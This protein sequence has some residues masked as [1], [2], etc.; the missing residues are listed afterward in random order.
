MHFLICGIAY[1]LPTYAYHVHGTEKQLFHYTFPLHYEFFTLRVYLLQLSDQ[2]HH[3]H[4][5]HTRHVPII[6][7][8]INRDTQLHVLLPQL[9]KLYHL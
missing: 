5:H 1:Y 3:A 9:A 6:C 4:H 7:H 2:I 8:N